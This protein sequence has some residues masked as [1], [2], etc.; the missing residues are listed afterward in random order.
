M[1]V[2]RLQ[3]GSRCV[4]HITETV[5]YHPEGGYQLRDLYV[6]EYDGKDA[7][8]KVLSRFVPTGNLPKATEILREH[9]YELPERMLKAIAAK[10]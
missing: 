1:Q 6:R 9:G 7:K 8:G 2:S 5:G 3:D 4:T 10:A